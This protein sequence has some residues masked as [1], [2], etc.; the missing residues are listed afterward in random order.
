MNLKLL[1]LPLLAL[2]T[3]LNLSACSRVSKY[4]PDKQKDYR[5]SAEIAVL[6]LPRDLNENAIEEPVSFVGSG[7]TPEEQQ[8][9][10][11]NLKSQIGEQR[12]R[13]EL[14]GFAGGATRLLIHEPFSRS[15]YVVG[16]ALSRSALEV[17]NRNQLD[18]AYIVQYD[19]NEKTIEDGSLMNEFD[20]FFGED[21]HQD[22]EYQI[23]LADNGA[24]HTEVIITDKDSVPLSDG[25]GLSLMVLLFDA[26]K[27][28]IAK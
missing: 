24:N 12:G 8:Q 9:A 13:V 14:V 11:E 6:H 27:N 7:L 16:K 19:P 1:V 23:R 28:D 10:K 26:I 4:F 2:L 17:T 25:A 3:V 21:L 15:W 5:Y 18:A 20:Y 22:E